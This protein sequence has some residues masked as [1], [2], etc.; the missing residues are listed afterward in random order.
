M[1]LWQRNL[2][3]AAFWEDDTTRNVLLT[4]DRSFWGVCLLNV[5]GASVA[6]FRFIQFPSQLIWWGKI[7]VYFAAAVAVAVAIKRDPEEYYRHRRMVMYGNRVIRILLY[8]VLML[9]LDEE[10]LVKFYISDKLAAGRHAGVVV[11]WILAQMSGSDLPWGLYFPLPARE[12]IWLDIAQQSMRLFV[13]ATRCERFLQ[14]PSLQ[15][16]VIFMCQGMNVFLSSDMLTPMGAQLRQDFDTQC[17]EDGPLLLTLFVWLF[18]GCFWPTF[19]VWYCELTLKSRFI[20]RQQGIVEGRPDLWSLTW[21]YLWTHYIVASA[22]WPLLQVVLAHRVNREV[23]M[24]VLH[25]TPWSS[26][27]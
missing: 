5:V 18:F 25:S 3:E 6:I 20:R 9:L 12:G 16:T 23:L 21:P 13:T 7:V 24:R 19:T 22:A 4:I 17:V 10:A 14:H 26:H 1:A 15:P 11:F 27:I 2:V 8:P